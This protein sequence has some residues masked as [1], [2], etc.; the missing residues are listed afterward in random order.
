MKTYYSNNGGE[1]EGPFTLEELKSKPTL[2]ETLVWTK[3]M[4]KWQPAHTFPELQALFH[5]PVVDIPIKK[6][7]YMEEI[8]ASKKATVLGLKKSYF[9]LVV[10]LAIIFV[11][12]GVL[13]YLQQSKQAILDERNKETQYGNVQVEIQQKEANQD[14]IQ[15]EIQ[16]RIVSENNAKYRKDTITS[17]IEE[18]KQ[19]LVQSK[20]DLALL[21]EDL[22]NAEK[23]RLLRNEERKQ[24][25]IDAAQIEIETKIKSIDN[26]DNELNLLY[27]ELETIH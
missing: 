12:V 11:G 18:V 17:R 20:Q 2:K 16:K 24:D 19:L 15:Q 5:S 3:G 22:Q 25:Q 23:F 8:P 27:L 26:L 7:G 4:E 21:K 1:N 6:S 14:R 13:K 10:L 9:Y